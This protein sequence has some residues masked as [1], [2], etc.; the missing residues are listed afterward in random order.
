MP[1]TSYVYAIAWMVLFLMY[2]PF[3]L[4]T[5]QHSTGLAAR[6]VR[7]GVLLART[8][9]DT[10]LL[11]YV[12]QSGDLY[13]NSEPIS[14]EDLPHKLETELARRADRSVFVEG[15]STT[16]YGSVARAISLVRAAGGEAILMTPKFRA[17]TSAP[18]H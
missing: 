12:D 7:P 15:D 4:A 10:G 11:V 9:G 3:Y 14:A 2:A 13:L 1:V 5:W 18:A 8:D 6:L 17:E 16:D